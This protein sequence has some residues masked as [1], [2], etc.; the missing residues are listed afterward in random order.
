MFVLKRSNYIHLY[1]TLSL[2][3]VANPTPV[4]QIF[5]LLKRLSFIVNTNCTTVQMIHFSLWRSV[6]LDLSVTA[7]EEWMLFFYPLSHSLPLFSSCFSVQ[8]PC[9]RLPD[10]AERAVRQPHVAPCGQGA[11]DV[12]T[13]LQ[14][15][16][17]H[18]HGGERHEEPHQRWTC[19]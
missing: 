13:L 10:G 6:Q 15:L 5:K 4:P 16:R 2:F 12:L 18:L 11:V 14:H 1:L 7:R 17:L 9:V 3:T 8:L 19:R